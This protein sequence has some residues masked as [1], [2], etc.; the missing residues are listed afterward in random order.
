MVLTLLPF[1]YLPGYM[2]RLPQRADFVE[3]VFCQADFRPVDKIVE[4][5]LTNLFFEVILTRRFFCCPADFRRAK[6]MKPPFFV[7]PS[8]FVSSQFCRPDF[9]EAIL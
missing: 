4:P 8:F 9:V 3:S 7:E 2:F 1:L 5:N 6:L